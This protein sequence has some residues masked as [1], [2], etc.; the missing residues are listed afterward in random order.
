VRLVKSAAHGREH[1]LR[2]LGPGATFN[3]A[4]VFDGGRI[5]TARWRSV[6]PGSATYRPRIWFG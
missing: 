5:P 2:V 6:R 3:D 4:A 1:V